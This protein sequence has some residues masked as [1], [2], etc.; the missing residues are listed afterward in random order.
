ML[1]SYTVKL[2]VLNNITNTSV[3]FNKNF[4]SEITT[5]DDSALYDNY[6]VLHSSIYVLDLF[7]Q[8][9]EDYCKAEQITS[10]DI[11]IDEYEI[12][13]ITEN[14]EVFF[15]NPVDANAF[16]LSPDIRCYIYPKEPP[17]QVPTLHG[18]AY[19]SN[20]I[21]WTWPEDE[22]YAH[23]L[24]SEPV[25]FN[26][27][28]DKTKIIAII[29]IGANHY[30]ETGLE[31]NTPYSRRL[32]NYTDTQTS[33]P[34]AEVTVITE[35]V[36]PKISLDK[37]FIERE[38][39]WTITDAEREVIKENL[40][41][42][43]SGI[44]DL[45][46]L[47]VYKQMDKDFY[48][49][50]KA[51]F[52]LTGKYIQREKRYNQVGFNYKICLEALETIEE[53]EGE[54]TFKLDAYPWQ[55]M[56]K[57]EYLWATRPVTIY[58]KVFATIDLFK[59]VPSVNTVKK[60]IEWEEVTTSILPTSFILSLDLST[61]MRY[62]IDN[63]TV[64]NFER[65]NSM[66]AAAKAAI[67]KMALVATSKGI[68]VVE[69]VILGWANKTHVEVTTDPTTA[70]ALIDTMDVTVANGY[71]NGHAVGSW[72]D[73]GEGLTGANAY[74]TQDVKI[75]LFFTDGFANT[76]DEGHIPKNRHASFPPMNTYI[77][78]SVSRSVASSIYSIFCCDVNRTD[79]DWP[80]GPDYNQAV[81]DAL[82]E[83]KSAGWDFVNDA[84][85]TSRFEKAIVALTDGT[86]TV[87]HK[88]ELEV[89]IPNTVVEH[90][91]VEI[92]S[93][94]LSFTFDAT[95]TP[96]GYKESTKRAEVLQRLAATKMSNKSILQL[97]TEAKEASDEWANGWTYSASVKDSAGN[98][99]GDV[100][101]NIY[102]KDTYAYGDEDPIPSLNFNSN[103]NYGMMGSI[104][105]N[106]NVPNLSTPDNTDDQYVATNNSFVWISGYTNAIIYDCVRYGH[107][108]VNSYSR[109]QETMFYRLDLATLLKNREN[110]NY[111][112]GD[113][114]IDT[115]HIFKKELMINV[116]NPSYMQ[117]Y[118]DGIDQDMVVV[119][120]KHLESPILNYRFNIID[121]DA[122]TPY[123]EILPDSN[124]ASDNKHVIVLTVY[125]AKN[126]EINSD[127][128]NDNYYS[129]FDW[130]NPSQEPLKFVYGTNSSWNSNTNSFDTDG[131]WITQYVHFFARKM[132]KTQEYYDEIPGP[133]MEPMYGL[134]NGRYTATNPSGKQDLIVDT[135]QFNIPT[136][137]LDYHPDSIKIY[138][139]ITEF[140]P[141]DALVSYKW[142]N[143]YPIGSGYTQL[144]GDYVTFSSD[145]ITYKDVEYFE[146][147]ATYETENI[148]MFSQEP[149]EMLQG[150]TRP[151]SNSETDEILFYD[152]LNTDDAWKDDCEL[153]GARSIQINPGGTLSGPFVT[154]EKGRYQVTFSGNNLSVCL[155][156]CNAGTEDIPITVTKQTD[157]EIIYRFALY[158]KKDNVEFKFTCDSN[159]AEASYMDGYF[160]HNING[161]YDSYYLN[162]ET[163]NGDVLATRYPTEILFDDTDN[164]VIP[165]TYRGIVN[166]TSKWSPRIHNG[167]YYI[168]QHERY[169][170]SEFDVKANFDKTDE[171]YY[172][173]G[174]VFINFDVNM[175]K[176]GGVIENYAINKDTSSELLQ[177]ESLFTWVNNQGLTLKPVLEGK[178]YKHYEAHTWQ[179]PVI[180]FDNPLTTAGT[181]NL[182]Y[183][184]ID[185][186]NTGLDLYIRSYDL[187]NGTW[188]DWSSFTNNTVPT[189][190]SAAYQLKTVLTATEKHTEY[191]YDDYLCCYLDWTEYI[192]ENLSTNIVT[193]TDH[194]TTGTY[195]SE[196]IAISKIIEYACPTG[197]ALDIYGSNDKVILNVAYSNDRNDLILE[198][199]QWQTMSAVN[200]NMNY[201]YYRFKITIPEHE[202]LYWVH[203]SV[204]TLE[205]E[206]VLPYIKAITMTGSYEPSN[207]TG[208]FSKIESFEIPKDGLF[209]EVV[210]KIGDYI[211]SEVIDRGFDLI[212]ITSIDIK[213]TNPDMYL[214]FDT[215]IL[216]PNPDISLLETSIEAAANE[217]TIDVINQLPYIFTENNKIIITGTPQQY[218]PVTV[219]DINKVPLKQIYNV[220][221]NDMLLTEIHTMQA[222]EN[223]VELKRNDFE[224]ET[225]TVWINDDLINTEDYNIVNHLLMFKN[226]LNIND[227]VTVTY[228]VANS[229][230]VDVDRGNNTTTITTYTNKDTNSLPDTYDE[231]I[232]DD[233]GT[234]IETITHKKKFKVMFE[235]NKHTNKF[236][237]KQ[238]SLNP[239][240][241]TDYS[242]FIYLTEE[243]NVPYKINIWCNPKR[244]K[245][246][247]L[248][249]ID[250]Q[251]EILD[252]IN[253]PVIAK[254]VKIDCN[255]GSIIC[256]NYETDI[257]GIVHIIYQ[258]PVIKGTDILTAKVLLDDELTNLQES[259]EIISY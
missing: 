33:L 15:E 182:D 134:V 148:E 127:S 247:G 135:P 257:N 206:A 101:R 249:S 176:D 216:L 226:F 191:Q 139:R 232:T 11:V 209:H 238:L 242:G 224:L 196:G 158:D 115:V 106:A 217:A 77:K 34:S 63:D 185:G 178:K 27:E 204:N 125:Y 110:K 58:A 237:A 169:L 102:I 83:R 154:L 73:W 88:E 160:V 141:D 246:N 122:Y 147:L 152:Y 144:N 48:E 52:T 180:L 215:N 43:K 201:K 192:D 67:N 256:D 130:T 163:D 19:D 165:V 86:T 42:F 255:N 171:T 156:S 213:S 99:I 223:Y 21:I 126:V 4:E 105:V 50:F 149:L 70:K 84:D 1:I 164:C 121:P 59:S 22:Q 8:E 10:N 68:P 120:D 3:I 128:L 49:K 9:V 64:V 188:T 218:C 66:K 30:I 37:Y 233:T 108:S 69:Y 74:P 211:S 200:L 61:S 62:A 17:L 214:L 72:T 207:I 252:I 146:T 81:V 103:Y 219:E 16:T 153:S 113:A 179:S 54:V 225:M 142:H 119:I 199:M 234:I 183:I 57:T 208:H 46:D 28:E 161:K 205:T 151:I 173:T 136:S 145:S 167:Y 5:I 25:D 239:V 150:I 36:N 26:S 162:I 12:A 250:I 235:T 227:V 90:K 60:V 231:V 79:S 75:M 7:S 39:D 82:I 132:Q 80:T 197:I 104:N 210:P 159:A 24:V 76:Y 155:Y 220:N 203:L 78:Q 2:T 44:G 184:N 243:H 172:N 97:L 137:V 32:I 94:V 140:Y 107:V 221:P 71:F 186:T 87:V 89:E 95:K 244:V 100:F 56:Y 138:I 6:H 166:A 131:H 31:P 129:L 123:Y 29:P 170:Y 55:E 157:E 175:E 236:V 228:N 18:T 114:N 98:V 248:D 91:T 96:V 254:E 133:N 85:F 195:N 116:P 51:Y 258:A 38:H 47:K 241:R 174:T 41:A 13:T 222:N 112:Y 253:N 65:L 189:V 190:L 118:G 14:V 53:Q 212:N 40:T 181:L 230:Y 229:F 259:I 177:D 92:S 20:T 124:P 202:K 194:I 143:E 93:E 109:P 168:N 251:I 187:E 245:A 193:I 240:Y 45:N 111:T 117:L 35:T 23:Y 198:N